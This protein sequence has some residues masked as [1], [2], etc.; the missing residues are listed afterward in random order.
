MADENAFIFSLSRNEK[1]GIKHSHISEAIY[2][3]PD[4]LIGFSNDIMINTDC[5]KSQCECSWPDAYETNG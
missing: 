4:Y 5:L 1:F 2:V 3:A